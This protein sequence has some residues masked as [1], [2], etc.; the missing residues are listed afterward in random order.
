MVSHVNSVEILWEAY[1]ACGGRLNS[2]KTFRTAG[3]SAAK[4]VPTHLTHPGEAGAPGP[5]WQVPSGV[6]ASSHLPQPPIHLPQL[7]SHSLL[8]VPVVSKG[9]GDHGNRTQV[10]GAEGNPDPQPPPWHKGETGS[11][12]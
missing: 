6:L 7:Q 2:E 4:G 12:P 9:G 1:H 11:F 3:P 8:S 10:Q 5:P